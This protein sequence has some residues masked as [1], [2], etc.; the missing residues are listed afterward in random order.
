MAAKKSTIPKDLEKRVEA[1]TL[2]EQKLR[3]KYKLERRML[4]IFP[5]SSKVPLTGRI[6]GR[7]L[8]WSRGR[9]EIFL[10]AKK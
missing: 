3:D 6:A 9:I 5:D 10:V 8:K 7:F 4:V 2:E 1:Y